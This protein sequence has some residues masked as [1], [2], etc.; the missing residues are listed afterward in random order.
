MSP[1]VAATWT[2]SPATLVRGSLG[3]GYRYP[4]IGELFVTSSTNVSQLVILPNPN[5]RSESSVTGELGIRQRLGDAVLVDAAVFNNEFRD[6]IEAG[7]AIRNVLLRPGD[8]VEVERAVVTFENVTRARIQGLEMVVDIEWLR[9][10]L[11]TQVGYTYLWHRDLAEQAPLKFRPR[12]L[13]MGS[14]RSEVGDAEIGIDVR[15][16][17]RVERIDDLLVRLAPIIDGDRRVPIR[18]VDARVFYSLSG[19]GVPLRVG[20]NV[21]NLFNYYYAELIGNLAPIRTYMLSVDG[22]W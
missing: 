9:R 7:V 15:F 14:L 8:S 1:K 3:T 13:L 5:L 4:S 10:L 11:S 22:A 18:V 21:K 12:H 16:A 17:S 19:W 20:L 2:V 6:L